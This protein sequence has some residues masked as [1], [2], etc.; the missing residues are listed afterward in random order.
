[1][2]DF[3]TP[4]RKGAVL[5][6][7]ASSTGYSYSLLPLTLGGFKP[8]A[9]NTKPNKVYLTLQADGGKVYFVFAN[10]DT[11]TLTTTGAQSAA[12]ADAAFV[13][14]MCAFVGDGVT[15]NDICI[16]RRIDTRIH[17]ICESGLTTAP[18]LRLWASKGAQ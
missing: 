5:A 8:A 15:T 10:D 3:S 12:S 2:I 17:I 13:N 7:T 18:I 6:L 14:T 16:D 1:M 9:G 11:I 4:P